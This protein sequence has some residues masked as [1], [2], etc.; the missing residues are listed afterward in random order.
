MKVNDFKK[1]EVVA[2]SWGLHKYN[3]LA[4]VNQVSN[5]TVYLKHLNSNYD[6]G[7]IGGCWD[8]DYVY[9]LS[10]EVFEYLISESEGWETREN[11]KRLFKKFA[12]ERGWE[13]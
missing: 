13:I 8:I 6:V 11:Y 5:D 12:K 7:A 3:C 9:H 1:D 2:Y 4:R 10:P